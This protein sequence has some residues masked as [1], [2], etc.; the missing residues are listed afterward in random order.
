MPLIASCNPR[1]THRISS[2]SALSIALHDLH[3]LLIL[4]KPALKPPTTTATVPKK[5]TA[6]P[7]NRTRYYQYA[8]DKSKAF[9]EF[10][11]FC[12]MLVKPP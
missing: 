1:S 2:L 7:Y 11:L 12:F 6:E 4:N 8:K 5:K 9:N 3:D 10:Y